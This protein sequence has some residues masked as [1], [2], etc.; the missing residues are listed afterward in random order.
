MSDDDDFLDSLMGSTPARTPAAGTPRGASQA[1]TA[2]S[3]PSTTGRRSRSNHAARAYPVDRWVLTIYDDNWAGGLPLTELPQGVDYICGQPELCP[4]TGRAHLQAFVIFSSGSNVRTPEQALQRLGLQ[5]SFADKAGTQT[6]KKAIDYTKKRDTAVLDANGNSQ[7]KELG[8][9][10]PNQRKV[11]EQT[12]A[13]LEMAESGA[14]FVDILRANPSLAIR[15]PTGILKMINT[16]QQD[17]KQTAPLKVYIIWGSTGLGKSH[18]IFRFLSDPEIVYNKL[19]PTNQQSTDFWEGYDAQEEVLFDD[20]NPV[21]YSVRQLLQ[22]LHE[23]PI[24]VQIKGGH[25]KAQYHTVYITSNVPPNMWYLSEKM[26]PLHKGNY[27]ALWRRI[28]KENICRFVSRIPD[29]ER[30]KTFEGLKAFQ[31][32]K[33]EELGLSVFGAND[34][35]LEFR[36]KAQEYVSRRDRAVL[37]RIVVEK[38]VD[39]WKS[40][41]RA[42]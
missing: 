2:S 13:I 14:K 5:R 32:K 18:S 39:S 15:C 25:A 26:D 31:D 30:I 10:P 38:M 24:R 12:E 27:D 41:L 3:M 17:R 37:E 28:P 16:V 36:K 4:T 35:E 8:Q 21:Q 20:F 29:D 19:H 33:C 11:G 40:G 1:S 7:W 42:D 34:D 6:C 23:W 9:V 22:Y